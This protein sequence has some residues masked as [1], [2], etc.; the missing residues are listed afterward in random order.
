MGMQSKLWSINALANELNIDRRT[1][2]KKLETLP[3][4]KEK[5]LPTRTEKQWLLK[6]VIRHLDQ[7]PAQSRGK[8]KRYVFTEKELASYG[9]EIIK[10][11]VTHVLLPKTLDSSTFLNI[12]VNGVAEDLSISK[13]DALTAFK[14]ASLGLVYAISEGFEDDK[15]SFEFNEKGFLAELA[16]LGN[17]G[18]F[19]K[20][21][22]TP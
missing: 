14:Y 6:D 22:H 7:T 1:L 18:F 19:R 2:A 15:L 8:E 3:P 4:A 20:Y 5:I 13:E 16:A 11:F 12:T 17:K 10:H 9:D 21:F